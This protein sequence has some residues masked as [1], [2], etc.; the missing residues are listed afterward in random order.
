VYVTA[1]TLLLADVF[2]RFRTV[3]VQQYG[4]DPAHYITIASFAHDACLKYTGIVIEL[5]TDVTMYAFL[6]GAVRGEVSQTSQRLSTANNPYMG[7]DYD[8]EVEHSYIS[9]LDVNR[10][11]HSLILSLVRVCRKKKKKNGGRIV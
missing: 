9:Y 1:D 11:V 3:C 4:L 10:Y 2:E 6:E 5:V 7:E 8:P